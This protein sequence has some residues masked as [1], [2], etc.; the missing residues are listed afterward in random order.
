MK[1]ETHK[2]SFHIQRIKE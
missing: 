2:I 1:K